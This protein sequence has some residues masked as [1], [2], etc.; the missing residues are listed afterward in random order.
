MASEEF[1]GVGRCEEIDDKFECIAASTN[2]GKRKCYFK[3]RAQTCHPLNQSAATI[4][5][6]LETAHTAPQRRRAFKRMQRLLALTK[7]NQ[8][9]AFADVGNQVAE[10][11]AA[12]KRLQRIV[13]HQLA[14]EAKQN[15]DAVLMKF[16]KY[17][18]PTIIAVAGVY[19]GWDQIMAFLT[20]FWSDNALLK[21]LYTFG[22][23]PLVAMKNWWQGLQPDQ[24]DQKTIA[25]HPLKIKNQKAP[26]PEPPKTTPNPYST[27]TPN[28]P[29]LYQEPPWCSSCRVQGCAKEKRADCVQCMTCMK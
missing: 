21:K 23:A 10:V 16:V 9:F 1:F 4:V 2:D 20:K 6:D 3:Q 18:I 14:L 8:E 24:P 17:G 25:E 28:N 29:F 15:N 12:D 13:K 5:R 26:T 7:F 27:M 19:Y 11:V 22:T